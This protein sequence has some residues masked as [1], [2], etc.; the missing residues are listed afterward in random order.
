MSCPP[1]KGA[2]TQLWAGVSPE[3]VDMNGQVGGQNTLFSDF[4]LRF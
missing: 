2:L 3:T 4:D 1:P